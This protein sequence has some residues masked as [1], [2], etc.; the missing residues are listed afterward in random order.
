MAKMKKPTIQKAHKI[1]RRIAKRRGASA[2][3]NPYAVG[4]AVAKR[5]AAKRKR[6]RHK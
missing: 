2:V 3:R 6:A 1:A 4:A 5:A